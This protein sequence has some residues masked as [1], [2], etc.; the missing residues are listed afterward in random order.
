MMTRLFCFLK[1]SWLMCFCILA[2]FAFVCTNVFYLLGNNLSYHTDIARDFLILDEMVSEHKLSLI[3]ART[4]IPGVFHGPLWYYL[5]LP[6]FVFS[7][8]NPMATGWFWLILSLA[9]GAGFYFC[10]KKITNKQTA[11]LALTLL[12]SLEIAL[13]VGLMQSAGAFFL[14]F[15]YFFLLWLYSQKKQWWQLALVALVA[16]MLIQF[17][18]AFGGPIVAVTGLYS[19]Y[20]IFKNKNYW[21]LCC[22]LIALLPLSTF[23]MFDYRH[24][25]LQIHSIVNYFTSS[26]NGGSDFSWL[27][28]WQ[29]RGEALID[30]FA[31][32]TINNGWLKISSSFLS[33]VFLIGAGFLARRD[34]KSVWSA[35]WLSILMIGGFWLVTL[36]FKGP[37]WDFY[38]DNL[39]PLI[40]FW[41]AYA[42]I[43]KKDWWWKLI[44]VAAVIYNFYVQWHWIAIFTNDGVE[45]H[46][47]FWSFYDHLA[48]DI[49][50]SAQGQEFSHY[51]YSL[52][53]YGYQAKYALR[54]WARQNR[55]SYLVNQKTPLTFLIIGD[56]Q[57]PD[58]TDKWQAEDLK[59]VR[60]ADE[61]WNY[62][63]GYRVKKYFLTDEEIA[64]EDNPNLIENLEFR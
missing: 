41:I 50:Q 54:Y 32:I 31:L 5:N 46:E 20:L 10:A 23:I 29:Q 43:R 11:L 21:H 52:N 47:I 25:F 34:K 33:F 40:V 64:V 44:L 17:Q 62:P 22:W 49:Y 61:E 16:G 26:S 28:Y 4:S 12:A 6:V 56:S 9:A 13:P 51:V 45:S 30:C 36:P 39:L 35:Y 27:A 3:G 15:I 24:D 48:S 1:K 63:S 18:M 37:I 59:I 38:Y 58:F 7:G 2:L 19:L 60:E 55:Q 42:V 8:G 57:H 14:S 53:L